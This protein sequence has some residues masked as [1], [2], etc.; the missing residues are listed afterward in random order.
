MLDEAGA[1]LPLYPSRDDLPAQR[2]R[3]VTDHGAVHSA[4]ASE[5]P[6]VLVVDDDQS[7]REAIG[8]LLRSV[9][10]RVETYGSA[11]SFLQAELP[12][13]PTCLVLDIRMPGQSGLDLQAELVREDIRIPIIFITG[14]AD[15]P[16][17]VKALK[18]GAVD[19]LTKPF[20]DQDLL[21]AVGSAL[22]R[23]SRERDEERRLSDVRACFEALT[24][25]EK[26]IMGRVADGAMNKQIA[27]ELGVTEITVKIHRGNMMRKMG[28]RSLPDLVRMAALLTP[29]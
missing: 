3:S 29:R 8:R 7:L 27:H 10:L 15:V 17:S 24:P 14:H 2:D 5:R 16:M 18:A 19:F 23:A 6:V 9:G 26:Q 12:T 1:E 28:A 11:Q 21:D 25:R 4:S 22:D 13:A 20:R